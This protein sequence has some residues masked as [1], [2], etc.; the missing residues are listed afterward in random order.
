MPKFLCGLGI[1]ISIAIYLYNNSAPRRCAIQKY[2]RINRHLIELINENLFISFELEEL[3]L[4]RTRWRPISFL[5]TQWGSQGFG[6]VL[7]TKCKSTISLNEDYYIPD[8]FEIESID[9]ERQIDRLRIP[10]D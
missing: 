8:Q 4:G 5:P 6:V 9:Q 10:T 2:R 3:C 1:Y 7:S